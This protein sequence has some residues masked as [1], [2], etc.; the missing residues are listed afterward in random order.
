MG[1]TI[2]QR[3]ESLKKR[4]VN[5]KKAVN[6]D[7]YRLLCRRDLLNMS[8]EL[9]KTNQEN[10][11]FKVEENVVSHAY[12]VVV[13]NAIRLLRGQTF[14]FMPIKQAFTPENTKNR[15]ATKIALCK[16]DV[17]R[18]AV[19][20]IM[21][22]IYEPIFSRH[23]H[24][25]RL[26][27]NCHTAL[28]EI[29]SK[30]HNI[31]WVVRGEIEGYYDSVDHHILISI[32]R[33]KIKDE[34]FIQLIWKI[35]RTR[36]ETGGEV[37]KVRFGIQK[38]GILSSLMVNI[39]LHELDKYINKLLRRISNSSQSCLRQNPSCRPIKRGTYLRG[40]SSNSLVQDE[41]LCPDRD[42]EESRS[43]ERQSSSLLLSCVS[44]ALNLKSE[45]LVFLRYEGTC[46]IGIMGRKNV[47]LHV[48]DKVE[49]FLQQSLRLSLSRGTSKITW[50]RKRTTQFLGFEL[51]CKETSDFRKHDGR[52]K[53]TVFCQ[54]KL[55]IPTLTLISKLAGN[56]FCTK[57]GTGKRKKGWIK[58]PDD[59]IIRRYNYILVKIRA[60][61]APASN[62]IASMRRIERILKFSCA[63]TL[64]AKRRTRIVLQLKR[65]KNLGLE[66]KTSYRNDV[67]DFKTKFFEYN[68]IL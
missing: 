53:K 63:H 52:Q 61:Y 60:Y 48:H 27:K 30:W 14:V 44:C 64:A 40:G 36:L 19:S 22:S 41:E 39:Y 3:L 38:N 43:V 58:Y 4:N 68:K 46:I 45:K 29:S 9:I 49:Q 32:L 20:M 35:L 42:A 34:R 11:Q 7:L 51:R 15:R 24:G 13:E 6:K 18:K 31:N 23:N 56:N 26:G 37:I 28:H 25:F 66:L 50:L 33:Q 54:T 5:N 65:L 47:A 21:Q 67:W 59:V 1:Q 57:L 2:L 8:Y 55:F 10:P 12:N 62:F 16:E 17:V